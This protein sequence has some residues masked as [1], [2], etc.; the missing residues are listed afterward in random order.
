MMQCND[1]FLIDWLIYTFFSRNIIYLLNV[2]LVLQWLVSLIKL[3]KYI[4]KLGGPGTHFRFWSTR[5]WPALENWIALNGMFCPPPFPFARNFG[6]KREHVYLFQ[7]SLV[8]KFFL[9]QTTPTRQPDTIVKIE[10]K[11][12]IFFTLWYHAFEE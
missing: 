3:M 6:L 7:S 1:C 2:I 12:V 8:D 11:I 10:V 4:S 9:R 5:V